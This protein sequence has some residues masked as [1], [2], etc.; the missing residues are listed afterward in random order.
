L[1]AGD[2]FHTDYLRIAV[3]RLLI[4]TAVFLSTAPI[5]AADTPTAETR[6]QIVGSQA[7]PADLRMSGPAIGTAGQPLTI[8]V[9]GLPAVD[10]SQTV[11]EQTK[12]IDSLR[13]DVSTPGGPAA[14]EQE[15]SMSVSPWE[16]R[17][18]LTLTPAANGTYLVVCDWNEPPYGLALH[19]V[20]VGGS[21]PVVVV[22]P[23]TPPDPTV[24]PSQTTGVAYLVIIRHY[25]ELTADQAAELLKLRQWSDSQPE[26]V[27]QLEVSPDAASSDD[28][29]AGYIAKAGPLPWVVLSRGRK[30]GKGAA[31]LWSGPLGTASELQAKFAEVVK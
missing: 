29:L 20:D 7:G 30:D 15:L 25:A 31:V 23:I 9:S 18:R 10:L 19:R 27:S 4:W 28:R 3:S 12:W 6:I 24:P 8:T 11:G 5:L 21:P 13:F 2:R 26:R 17:L 14:L 22:P 1:I 16:W